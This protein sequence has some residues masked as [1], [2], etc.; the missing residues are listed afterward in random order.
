MEKHNEWYMR[1]KSR[2]DKV[3]TTGSCAAQFFFVA[4]VV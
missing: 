1:E 4:A 3:H 2:E